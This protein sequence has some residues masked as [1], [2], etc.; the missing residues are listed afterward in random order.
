VSS[1]PN[2]GWESLKALPQA[3][4]VDLLKVL[5]ASPRVRADAIRQFYTRPG[6]QDMAEVLI[7]I[8]ADEFLRAALVDFLTHLA[9]E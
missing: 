6:G 8:E 2:S 5:K 3:A 9:D 1:S 4:R 7:D